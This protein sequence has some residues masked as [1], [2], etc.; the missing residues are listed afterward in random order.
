VLL[1]LT[2]S[3]LICV[4]RTTNDE[5]SGMSTD[6]I[7]P[8][9]DTY[10][11]LGS[12]VRGDEIAPGLIPGLLPK[13]YYSLCPP[14]APLVVVRSSD[15]GA[16]WTAG[17]VMDGPRGVFPRLARD[18]AGLIALTYGGLSGVPRRPNPGSAISTGGWASST[19]S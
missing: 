3:E 15:G 19:C 9:S 11:D 1:A 12:E 13:R 14:N 4:V 8:A 18:S 2:D 17:A 10:H 16:S 5:V 6:Q 7:G